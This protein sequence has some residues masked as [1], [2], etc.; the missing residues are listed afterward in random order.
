MGIE[1]MPNIQLNHPAQS[2]IPKNLLPPTNC[3]YCNSTIKF[4]GAFPICDNHSCYMRVYG[5]LQKFVDVLDIKGAGEETLR[6]LAQK[7]LLK[8]PAD[9]Y[10]LSLDNFSQ[11]ERK[12]SKHYAK[13][14]EGLKA[15]QQMTVAQFF[16]S[17]D[18]EGEGTFDA[19]TAVP[20]L[21]TVEGIVKAASDKDVALFAKA[22]RVS[23][24]R[25]AGI[26]DQI[27]ELALE[28]KRLLEVVKIKKSGS[29]L[30]GITFCIT[31]T[32][33][34][35]RRDIENLIKD[36]GGLVSSSV[37]SR[38]NYLICGTE[39]G[40]DKVAKAGKLGIP[41]INEEKLQELAA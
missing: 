17:L 26:I 39:P 10:S 20:G 40:P 2:S 18:I 21:D 13:L 22:V 9:L 4:D 37:T 15:R 11:V 6:V 35:P 12:G 28:I 31:G 34:K 5:R 29:K 23:P 27:N 14:Q 25:A 33:G 1:Y 30:L 41:V 19:I 32:L 36:L 3:P 8:T 24:E 7:G 16:A 38:T